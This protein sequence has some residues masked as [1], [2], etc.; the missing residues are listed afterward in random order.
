M[1]DSTTMATL[2]LFGTA[3]DR[4]VAVATLGVFLELDIV[5]KHTVAY[6]LGPRYPVKALANRYLVYAL[7]SRYPVHAA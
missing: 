7:G 1:A 3:T 5:I 6:G 4:V 2:G